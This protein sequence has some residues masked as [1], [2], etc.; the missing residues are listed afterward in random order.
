[1][2]EIEEINK[3]IATALR[4]WSNIMLQADADEWAYRLRYT[5]KDLFRCVYMFMHVAS[6]IGI[7]KG[8]IGHDNATAI[9]EELRQFILKWTGEDMHNVAEQ[10]KVK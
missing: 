1:M 3:H 7:K 8:I 2:N 6:N 5:N 9:G 4:D 10:I